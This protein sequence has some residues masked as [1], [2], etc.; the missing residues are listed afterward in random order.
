MAEVFTHADY[1]QPDDTYAINVVF[2][3]KSTAEITA[4]QTAKQ[5]G[6]GTLYFDTT[7]ARFRLGLDPSTASS[8]L[9][10]E[11]NPI[12]NTVI[13]NTTPA[14]ATFANVGLNTTLT[15]GSSGRAVNTTAALASLSLA[16][17]VQSTYIQSPA[18]AIT[19]TLP[20]VGDGFRCKVSFGA[21]TTVTWVGTVAAGTKTS[22]AAG[23][24][25]ELVY[26]TVAGTPTNSAATTW[27]PF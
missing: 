22:F 10:I 14:S 20:T 15:T 13:G 26:N 17:G 11:A 8:N 27:Y 9:L 1:A 3:R 21:A 5:F 7:A 25:Y 24:T 18:A 2:V 23:D 12:N 6:I 19:L 16:A 4:L